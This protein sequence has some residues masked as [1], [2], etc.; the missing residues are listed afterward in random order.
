MNESVIERAGNEPLLP[1]DSSAERPLWVVLCVMA[2]F[3]ALALLSARIGARSYSQWQ[4]DLAGSATVQL[5]QVSAENRLEKAEQALSIIHA[6]KP[7]VAASRLSDTDALALIKP[8]LGDSTGGESLGGDDLAL[9]DGITLPVLIRLQNST[10]PDREALTQALGNAGLSVIINDHS[11]WGDDIARSARASRLSSWLILVM[12]FLAS[13]AAT[14]FATQAAM[15][16]QAGVIS[17]FAQVGASD[18]FISRLFILRSVKIGAVAG[19]IGG[20]GALGFIAL[21]RLLRGPASSGLLPKL[22]LGLADIALLIGLAMV[23]ALVCAAAAAFTAK[24]ILQ[25]TRLYS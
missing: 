1:I 22:S 11:Q 13:I 21:Y 18:G 9:L 23:F 15:S 16:A 17:V 5:S 4:S 24:K 6:T 3:A 8:W 25:S 20:L 14:I 19:A 10:K 7:A 2:F 12:T